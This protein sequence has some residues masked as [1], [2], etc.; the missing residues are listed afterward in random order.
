[1]PWAPKKP[2]RAPGCGALTHKAHCPAHARETRRPYERNRLSSCKRGYGRR[3]QKLRLL[4]LN[5]Y[6]VCAHCNRE[7]STDVDHIIPKADGGKDAMENLQGLCATCHAIKTT[8]EKRERRR[9]AAASTPS[10]LGHRPGN[11]RETS[12]I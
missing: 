9:S 2:C 11:A 8:R 3:W 10:N 1:M 5:R 12:Q 6:P 7:A 4:V